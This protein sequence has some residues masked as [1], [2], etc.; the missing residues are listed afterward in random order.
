MA[1]GHGFPVNT[2]Q[3]D[4]YKLLPGLNR[5]FS[6]VFADPPYQSEHISSLPD[7]VFFHGLLE[8]DG[9]FILEHGKRLQFENHPNFINHRKYSAVHLSFFR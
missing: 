9:L 6:L 4:V 3:A 5:K 2:I 8:N 7:M 1:S